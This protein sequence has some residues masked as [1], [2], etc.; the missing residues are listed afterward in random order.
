MTDAQATQVAEIKAALESAAT[1]DQVNATA[2]RYS[3]AVQELSEAPSAT[4][5]TMAIQIRNLAKCRRDRIH[6]MQRTAS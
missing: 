1:I 5:R 2:I 4:A 6:R 3:T